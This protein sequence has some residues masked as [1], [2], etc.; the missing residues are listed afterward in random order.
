MLKNRFTL[1]R[2]S[3]FNPLYFYFVS[4]NGLVAW[5]TWLGGA[6]GFAGLM[7]FTII[8]PVQWLKNPDSPYAM[9]DEQVEK[10]KKITALCQIRKG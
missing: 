6:A 8:L 9:P 2:H 5:A 10:F 4:A 3:Y 7:L 1:L